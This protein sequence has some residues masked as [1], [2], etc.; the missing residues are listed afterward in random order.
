MGKGS[1][2]TFQYLVLFALGTTG[3]AGLGLLSQ[4]NKQ[5]DGSYE[6]S[7]PTVVLTAEACKL[8]ISLVML[9]RELG[10]LQQAFSLIGKTPLQEFALF[11][12]PA[13]LYSV[14]NNLDMLCIKYMDSATFQVLSQI[15]IA[16][17]GVIWWCVFR[18]PLGLQKSLALLLLTTGSAIASQPSD[19]QAQ[20]LFCTPWGI[21]L[22]VV[23]A[24]CGACAGVYNE[25]VYKKINAAQSIHLQN[26]FLY[27]F[28]VVANFYAYVC[29]PSARTT[30]SLFK[31]YGVWTWVLV[32]NYTCF[33]LVIGY[34]MKHLD[35]IHKLFMS[36]SSMYVS[37]FV[38]VFVFGLRPHLTYAVGLATV[39]VALGI[40][41]RG[42][43]LE[44]L[45]Q[46]KKY[47]EESGAEMQKV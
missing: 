37:A 39:T 21:F 42:A 5:A 43:I 33:G 4:L 44:Y 7:M 41:H 38:T 46:S 22:K 18:K 10:G 45:A 23:E 2:S 1:V 34:I 8:I 26:I 14:T 16:T 25:Y 27:F 15:K 11:A 13:A 6:F 31:G 35:N 30:G 20:N 32:A 19:L 28:G 17:T 29:D 24:V 3:Y 36:G 47:D 9:C 12:V 40:F